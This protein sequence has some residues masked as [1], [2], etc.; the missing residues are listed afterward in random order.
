[1]YA[2]MPG[3]EW[4]VTLHD[5]HSQVSSV[6]AGA[7]PIEELGFSRSAVVVSLRCLLADCFQLEVRGILLHAGLTPGPV[8][9]CG[10]EDAV[11]RNRAVVFL[12]VPSLYIL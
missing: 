4:P 6:A 3:A 2:L 5:A 9:K 12:C 1:M 8:A 11:G 10:L 7:I